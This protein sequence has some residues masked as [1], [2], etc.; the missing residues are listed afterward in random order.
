MTVLAMLLLLADLRTDIQSKSGFVA[1]RI[2]TNGE[3]HV[4]WGSVLDSEPYVVF[5]VENGRIIDL[6][7]SS[8]GCD[9]FRPVQVLQSVSGKESAAL[10]R[11]LV[12]GERRIAKKAIHALGMHRD[13]PDDDLIR[14]ARTHAS[15][16]IRSNAIFW[17]GQ[18]AGVKSAAALRESVDNDPDAEVR[19]KAVFA[20]SQLPD[21]QSIPLLIELMRT[22][23]NREVRKKSAFWLGQK[24]DPRALQALEDVLLH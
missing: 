23:K 15:R 4:C 3:H 2:P 20:I 22:H 21:D 14:I 13:F 11:E 6:R 8:P 10:L 24:N 5:E 19:T 7:I 17:V 9:E 1:Y 18:R 12:D 16:D